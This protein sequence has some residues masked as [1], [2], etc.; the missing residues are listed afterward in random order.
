MWISVSNLST[1]LDNSTLSLWSLC[2]SSCLSFNCWSRLRFWLFKTLDFCSNYIFEDSTLL[3][4]FSWSKSLNNYR[5][6]FSSSLILF[7]LNLRSESYWLYKFTILDLYSLS[8]VLFT[9]VISF[10]FLISISGLFFI[11]EIWALRESFSDLN[12]SISTSM[13]SLSTVSVLMS[14]SKSSFSCK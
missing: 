9:T 12:F 8:K 3:L 10:C 7:S 6:W 5:F 4:D 1:V 2:S 11:F 13:F 14:Y